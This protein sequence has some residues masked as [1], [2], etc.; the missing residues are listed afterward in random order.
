MPPKRKLPSPV[1][2]MKVLH[3]KYDRLLNRS[4]LHNEVDYKTVQKLAELGVPG[5]HELA[6]VLATAQKFQAMRSER[7]IREF[8]ISESEK[9]ENAERDPVFSKLLNMMGAIHP[10]G[11]APKTRV[12]MQ[13]GLAYI[14]YLNGKTTRKDYVQLAKKLGVDLKKI[15]PQ[16]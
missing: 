15:E 14:R 1:E 5:A 7:E 16:K 2:R 3:A 11:S 12:W 10:L 4:A 8:K 6:K 13:Y 9:I